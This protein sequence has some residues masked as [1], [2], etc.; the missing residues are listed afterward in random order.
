MSQSDPRATKLL[1]GA[2]GDEHNAQ[3]SRFNGG[4]KRLL[5]DKSTHGDRNSVSDVRH[6]ELT[7]ERRFIEDRNEGLDEHDSGHDEQTHHD[8]VAIG[9]EFAP[10]R[11]E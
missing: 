8:L 2:I 6:S 5:V 10:Q 9:S 3:A 7:R 1:I 4:W 11:E